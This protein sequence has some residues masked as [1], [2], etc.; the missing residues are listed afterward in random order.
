MSFSLSVVEWVSVNAEISV[1]SLRFQVQRQNSPDKKI[2][3][4]KPK[5]RILSNNRTLVV[6][7]PLFVAQRQNL[8][9]KKIYEQETGVVLP[10]IVPVEH[11]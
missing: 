4:K 11:W 6:G 2:Y 7:L 8:P 9:Y 10:G 3:Q 1:K 5:N